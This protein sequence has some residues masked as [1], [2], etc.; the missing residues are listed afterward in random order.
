MRR[1]AVAN[2][3]QK[4]APSFLDEPLGDC[5]YCSEM[6]QLP[7][8][9]T[10]PTLYSFDQSSRELR[11]SA[12]KKTSARSLM[13]IGASIGILITSLAFF[14]FRVQQRVAEL[15]TVTA[16]IATDSVAAPNAQPADTTPRVAG[17]NQAR[18]ATDTG[19]GGFA[20]VAAEAPQTCSGTPIFQI[21][22]PE[23]SPVDHPA[24]ELSW[25]G[26]LDK[27]PTYT[28]PFITDLDGADAFPWRVDPSQPD[29][30]S[31]DITF[32]YAGESTQA[33]L[34]LSWSPGTTGSGAKVVELDGEPVG[35]T[36]VRQGELYTGKSW[37]QLVFY[38]DTIEFTLTPG[39]HTLTIKHVDGESGDAA[40]W[41]YLRLTEC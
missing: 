29:T 37:H 12:A 11:R 21:G 24:D 25:V 16:Q 22:E 10:T 28:N 38:V 9:P 36:A 23:V 3:L 34:E 30:R 40:V 6:H 27:V 1:F 15:D 17:I 35:N 33:S 7:A 19:N 4:A 26:A 5:Y 39:S 31:T 14:G 18:P 41:D 32:E 2:V 13:L 8:D 20:P